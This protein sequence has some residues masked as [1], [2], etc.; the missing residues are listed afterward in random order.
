MAIYEISLHNNGNTM[1]VNTHNTM[2][3]LSHR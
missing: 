3:Y 2:S 1:Q